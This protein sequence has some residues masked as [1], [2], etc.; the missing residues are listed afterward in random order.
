MFK[1]GLYRYEEPTSIMPP[2]RM[3]SAM[4]VAFVT[5]PVH[6]SE[7]PY[8]VTNVPKLCHSFAEASSL[9]GFSKRPEIWNNYTAPQ[10][11]FSQFGLYAVAPIVIVN[12]LDPAVHKEDVTDVSVML[13]G[14]SAVVAFEGILIDTLVV[15]SSTGE[16]YEVGDDYVAAFNR[17]GHVVI[18]ATE[19]GNINEGDELAL[20]FSALAPEKV[21]VYDVI[22][23]Y[24]AR[25]DANLGLELV[26]DV[27]PRFRLVPGSVIAPGFSTNPAVA[28]VMETK[29]ANINGHFVAMAIND[30][31]TVLDDGDGNLARLKYTDVPEWKH[32]NNYVSAKQ[33]NCYPMLRLGEQMYYY[34]TQLAGL[35]GRVDMDNSG[36]PHNS[37]SNKNLNINGLCDANGDEMMLDTRRA[38]FL[39]SHGIVAADNFTNGWVAW[40]NRTGIFPSSTDAKDSF[41]PIRRMFNWIGNTIILTHWRRL[42]SPITPRLIETIVDSVNMWFNGLASQE[43]ILGGRIEF[44]QDENP[45]SDLINGIVTFRVS[46]SPP[47]PFEVGE[48]ILEYDPAYLQVLFAE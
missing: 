22:G 40:G 13:D 9:F 2:V 1:H 6:L 27:F 41:I 29:A 15:K 42:G 45:S 37:P 47:P 18:H 25:K 10:V 34:S 31:P 24:D 32:D 21:D 12:V 26:E 3:D 7:N 39:N 8:E 48:F 14:C 11:I 33:I 16:I 20:E 4:P 5:A 44:L 36:I 23:G 28:A 38:N 35:L 30:L 19:D 43:F 46:I 17:D